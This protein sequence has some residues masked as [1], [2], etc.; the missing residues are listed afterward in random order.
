VTA[1]TP[2]ADRHANPS[3]AL[4]VWSRDTELSRAR[5]KA[6]ADHARAGNLKLK[7]MIRST[8]HPFTPLGVFVI[9]QWHRIG[10]AAEHT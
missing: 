8:N 2:S 4:Q 9:D 3:T 1:E 10:V 5:A 6:F 7:L